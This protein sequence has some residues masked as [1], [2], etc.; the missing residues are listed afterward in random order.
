MCEGRFVCADDVG[1]G[2]EAG[3]EDEDVAVGG[4]CGACARGYRGGRGR[5]GGGG[6]WGG[7]GEVGWVRG[8]G[9]RADCCVGHEHRYTVLSPSYERTVGIGRGL[10]DMHEPHRANVVDVYFDF[11]NDYECLAV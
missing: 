7:I 10:Y 2:E 11:E 5:C 1:H 8:R 4:V 3:I 9:E 6:C